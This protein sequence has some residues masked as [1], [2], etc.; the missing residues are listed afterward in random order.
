MPRDGLRVDTR[1][2]RHFRPAVG[3]D[4]PFWLPIS[5]SMTLPVSGG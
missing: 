2:V 1:L 5:P 3:H 4:S